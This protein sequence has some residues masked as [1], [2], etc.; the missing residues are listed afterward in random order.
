MA[1]PDSTWY[2]LRKTIRRH[3]TGFAAT[4]A[5]LVAIVGGGAAA[6]VQAHR[7]ARSAERE[8]VVKEFVTEVFRVNSRSD[9]ANAAL[10]KLPAE[11]L[12]EHGASLIQQRFPGQ[13]DLQAEL[14]GVVGGIFADMGANKLAA[15]YSTRQ[16]E[17]LALLDAND[18]TQARALVVLS[19]ALFDDDRLADS[20]IRL[21]RAVTLAGSDDTVA[22]DALVMLARVQWKRGQ[23]AESQVTQ[24]A[25]VAR[26]GTNASIASSATAWL[27]WLEGQRIQQPNRLDKALPVF[28]QAIDLALRAE[29]PAS[30]TAVDMR[31]VLGSKLIDSV[32]KEEALKVVEPALAVL[33]SYGG[34]YAI[35]AAEERASF[36]AEMYVMISIPPEEATAVVARSQAVIDQQPL[37]VPEIIRVELAYHAA[38]VLKE[39]D[40]VGVAL[41]LM[42]ATTAALRKLTEDPRKL[43][44]LAD[45][46][47]QMDFAAGLH[48][49]ADR[50]FRERLRLMKV[51]GM[52]STP[53][54][55]YAYANIAFN[56]TTRGRFD[57]AQA[58]LDAAPAFPPD[59]ANIDGGIGYSQAVDWERTR[60]AF[61]RHDIP[62]ALRTMSRLQDADTM[63]W[64]SSTETLR[65]EIYCATGRSSEGLVLIRRVIDAQVKHTGYAGDP[66][67]ARVR[68]IAG[69]CA[70]TLGDRRE[71]RRMSQLAH[72]AF[73]L[74]PAVSP[75]FRAPLVE[76]DARLH[77]S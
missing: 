20:E 33:E 35:R 7:A 54:A 73:E 55:A 45:N 25:A 26:L 37:A 21:R 38:D 8:R 48:D 17:A 68:A 6:V 24:R 49:E 63:E 43:A 72:A 42:A 10:R 53:F 27:K 34:P 11:M 70:L 51:G 31:L 32:G 44:W 69:L 52:T 77:K 41:P 23:R 3:R 29:G 14:Y 60:L 66:D 22:S 36:W 5:V 71:A 28:Y 47:A 65:S 59:V 16:I 39:R 19:R 15:D 4:G 57:E 30:R 74:E 2:R 64:A 58:I 40:Q 75:F 62:G 56:A 46:E 67:V 76:L 1:Q 9:P 18:V 12:L 13:P 61:A 50:L